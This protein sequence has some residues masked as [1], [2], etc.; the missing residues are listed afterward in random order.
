V[1]PDLTGPTRPGSGGVEAS[2]PVTPYA[3]PV[4][5]PSAPQPAAPVAAPVAAPSASGAGVRVE[6]TQFRGVDVDM[7]LRRLVEASGS[8]LHLSVGAP[9]LMRVHGTIKPVPGTAVLT[10]EGLQEALTGLLS[11]DQRNT[12]A[13]NRELDFAYTVPGVS[14]FRANLMVQ[15]GNPGGVFRTIPSEIK[16]LESLGMPT[17][18]YNFAGLPRGLVLV[19]GPTGSGKSTTLAALV[20]RANRTRSGHILTVEDPI[21]FLH[22]HRSCVV[23]QR[24]VG[25]DTASFAEALRHV[26]RQDPDI[27][28][29]GELR[30][31]ETISIALTAAETGH[32]VFATLHTQSAQETVNRIID[33]F[34]PGQQQQIRSQLAATLKGVVCQALVKRADGKGRVAAAEIMVVNTAVANLIRQDQVHQIQAALQSGGELG[35]Q[36]LNQNLADLVTRNLIE[37]EAAEEVAS[38]V[39]DLN[40]LIEGKASRRP[41]G[42]LA[43]MNSANP[44][45]SSLSGASF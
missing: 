2:L 41:G 15:K 38:D 6:T 13:T 45:G 18:L 7:L 9:P 22:T 21:E 43:G 16:P 29:I 32:L 19:T 39:Q 34:P 36:T 25:T 28:L 30:D 42:R 37:R 35:M 20:D 40:Q 14:R 26:L 8:D 44:N 4:I 3:T 33:V 23:N 17:M 12:F 5:P 27:I 24:E 31:L 10:T 11:P 1:S